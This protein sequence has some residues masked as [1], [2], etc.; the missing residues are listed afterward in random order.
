MGTMTVDVALEAG[1]LLGEGPA[2]CAGEQCLYW[3]D[4]KKPSVRSWKPETGEQR[5]WPVPAEF[6]SMALRTH[7][8]RVLALR[9][10]FALLDLQ[11]G[12][13]TPLHDPEPNLHGN[14]FNDGKCDPQGRF[15]AGTMDCEE[16]EGLGSLYRLDPDHTCHRTVDGIICSNGLGWSPDG[17]TMYY[18]DTWTHRI[19][20]FDFDPATGEI[21][22]RRV[23]TEVPP[24]EGGPDGLAVD[25]E[26]G[27]WSARW[28]G[29]SVVRHAPDGTVDAV[30]EVPVPRPTSCAFGGPDLRDLYITS[31]SVGLD[32]AA[33]AAAP[34]SGS[35]FRV[36]TDV[37]GQ[38]THEFGG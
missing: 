5:V 9:D 36:R 11:T 1:D 31:A 33:L 4:I 2:W 14:R 35:V 6:G 23:F 19:D 37:S 26:G 12:V 34:L 32:Q 18:T 20:A 10:G 17:R 29:W 7:G 28:D 3:V 24:G 15:W 27:V 21:A 22:N 25:A 8:G 16:K 13:V 30:I 38:M